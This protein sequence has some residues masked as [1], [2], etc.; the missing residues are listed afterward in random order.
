MITPRNRLILWTAIVFLACALVYAAEPAT[1]AVSL[2]IVLAFLLLVA[3]DAALAPARLDAFRAGFGALP[4]TS[5]KDRAAAEPVVFRLTKDRENPVALYVANS[6]ASA[7]TL[8]IALALPSD[9]ES[10]FETQ[11]VLLQPG[12]A[13]RRVDWPCTPRKRGQFTL[14]NIYLETPSPLGFWDVRKT[15]PGRAELRAYPNLLAERSRLAAIFLNRGN[16]G[17]HAQRRVGKGREFEQLR[18]YIPGDGFEDIH[19]KATAR[20]ARP[21]TKVYQVERTQEIYV[22]VD[23]SRLSARLAPS[24]DGKTMVSQLDRF[25]D[26]ALVLG[27]VAQKQGDLFGLVTFSDRVDGFVQARNGQAHFNAVRDTLYTLQPKEMDPDFDELCS[28]IRLRLRRRA[29]LFFLTNL[30]DPVLAEHLTRSLDLL[31]RRHLVLVNMITPEGVRPLFSNPNVSTVDDVYAHLSGHEQ[32]RNLRELQRVL[33]RR[34]VTMS[35]LNDAT[36][37]LDL[38]S[39]YM[40]VKQRQL[41]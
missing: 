4:S 31:N 12:L 14:E 20:R 21:V 18:E 17:L 1:A 30:D 37:T 33:H 24:A 27:L 29:L 28:F 39:Q 9:I 32:W 10:P 13:P 25:L 22:V 26:A 34:G 19:W 7:R 16:L 35:L 40:S 23:A 5:E 41:L 38:V 2:L 36:L 8:R 3:A 6:A 15:A 11:T